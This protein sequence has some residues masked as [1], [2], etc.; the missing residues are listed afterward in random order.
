MLRFAYPAIHSIREHKT[1]F[2][3]LQSAGQ[4]RLNSDP[5]ILAWVDSQLL[6]WLS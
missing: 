2:A 5:I 1:I 4:T 3:F 6:S